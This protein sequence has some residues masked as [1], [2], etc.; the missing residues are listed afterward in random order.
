[1]LKNPTNKQQ[2]F[3]LLPLNHPTFGGDSK[4]AASAWL[5][6]KFKPLMRSPKTVVLEN[7][8][9]TIFLMQDTFYR[10]FYFY[11]NVLESILR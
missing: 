3:I 1:L 10:F 8:I 7:H 9:I 5:L 11:K 6:H 2:K 4:L